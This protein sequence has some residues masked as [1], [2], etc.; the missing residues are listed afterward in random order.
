VVAQEVG[1]SVVC[2][3]EVIGHGLYRGFGVL[4]YKL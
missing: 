3:L 4:R 2:A 1:R